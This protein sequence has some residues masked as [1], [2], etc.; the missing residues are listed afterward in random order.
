M[1]KVCIRPTYFRKC[2]SQRYSRA[3]KLHVRNPRCNDPYTSKY[4]D[5]YW[6]VHGGVNTGPIVYVKFHCANASIQS[7]A[8]WE[9]IHIEGLF[10]RF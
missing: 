8:V 6:G 10:G 5:W 9:N 3:C 7:D 4:V 2:K 1:Q